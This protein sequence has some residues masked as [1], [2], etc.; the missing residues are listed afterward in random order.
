MTKTQY[1]SNISSSFIIGSGIIAIALF[2]LFSNPFYAEAAT[3]NRS[4]ELGMNGSDVSV[5]QTYLSS[6]VNLYPS[7]LVTG[8]FGQLTKAGVERFQTSQGIIS[9]GTPETTGYG[10]VGPI[11]LAAL[12][13]KINGVAFGNVSPTINSVAVGTGSTGATVSWNTNENA[14]GIVYYSAFPIPMQEASANTPVTIGGS[15][16]LA[17]VDLRSSHSVTL[18]G[19]QQNTT[20]HYVIYARD[21]SNNESIT[22]PT[23]FRTNN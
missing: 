14:S 19:L 23:T 11:T 1:L 21:G 8:Y 22:W 5:L 9:S 18:S 16:V 12:N 6:D 13:Q 15:S 2:T 17:N 20:Y 4:L 3:L 10:R 7:G